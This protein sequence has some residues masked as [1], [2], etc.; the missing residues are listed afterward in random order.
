MVRIPEMN[1]R[2]CDFKVWYFIIMIFSLPRL[3]ILLLIPYIFLQSVLSQQMH[4][5]KHISCCISNSYPPMSK[6]VG[7]LYLSWIV[8]YS[9]YLLVSVWFQ[10]FGSVGKSRILKRHLA[11]LYWLL[12]DLVLSSDFFAVSSVVLHKMCNKLNFQFCHPLIY[13]LCSFQHICVTS[14]SSCV[15]K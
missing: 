15:M 13:L 2:K 7:V 4:L 9:L 10:I 6:H 12:L 11:A 5:I 8:F 3:R 1:I 14:R